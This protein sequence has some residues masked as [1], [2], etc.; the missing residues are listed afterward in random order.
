MNPSE[1]I[2]N[3]EL[4]Y[5]KYSVPLNVQRHMK[6]VAAVA[7]IICDNYKEEINKE[8]VVASCLIHDLG[9]LIK[10]D[11]EKKESSVFLDKE[12]QKR[13]DFFKRKQKEMRKKYGLNAE[14][15]DLIIAEE[16]G[17]NK[18]VLDLISHK[19][20]TIQNEEFEESTL[21]EKIASYADLRGSPVGVVSAEKRMDDYHKRYRFAENE[22]KIEHS[23]KFVRLV[24]ELEK[25][26]FSKLTIKPEDITKES[27]KKYVAKY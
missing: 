10:I 19:A 21:G 27:I 7:E 11:F 4:I 14:K 18:K 22:E 6:E 1:I 9:N 24:K 25:E 3:T 16:I 20:I 8:E 23:K 13:I 26:L 17:V 12:D 5:K 15:A 2:L